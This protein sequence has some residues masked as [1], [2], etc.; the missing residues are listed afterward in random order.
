M[1]YRSSYDY[2]GLLSA[3]LSHKYTEGTTAN[4]RLHFEGNVLYSYNTLVAVLYNDFLAITSHNCLSVTTNRQLKILKDTYDG[5]ILYAKYIHP[6]IAEK[7]LDEYLHNVKHL[8]NIHKR[9]R[10][11]SYKRQ[12]R[13]LLS[14]MKFISQKF[15]IPLHEKF[16]TLMLISEGLPDR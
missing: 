10:K 6:F 15:N 16:Y 8:I 2:R 12:I 3:Y 13:E 5:T 1:Q 14:T 4:N 11:R 7:V 9:A